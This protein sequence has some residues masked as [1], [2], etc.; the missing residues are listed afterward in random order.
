MCPNLTVQIPRH[1]TPQFPPTLAGH[2]DQVLEVVAG[3]ETEFANKVLGRG[4]EVAVLAVLE[5]GHVVLGA[6]KVGVGRDARRALEPLK[7]RLGLG[8]DVGVE[9]TAAEKLVGRY[10]LLGPEFLARVLF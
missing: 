6:P 10:A 3:R 8:L 7:A 2:V 9:R 1:G 5:A 4:F